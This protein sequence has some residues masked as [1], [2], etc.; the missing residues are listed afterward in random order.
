MQLHR[1]SQWVGM[2][3]LAAAVGACN[4][5]NVENPNAP[6]AK[7]ALSDAHTSW[8]KEQYP[9]LVENALRQLLASS[10]DLQTC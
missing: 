3:T 8:K 7:R 2:V 5:L 9:A 1:I 10:P 4:D 6:D